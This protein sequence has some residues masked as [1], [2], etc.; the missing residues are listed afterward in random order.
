MWIEN[1][2]DF[3]V[4]LFL[5]RLNLRTAVRKQKHLSVLLNVVQET[6]A[7]QSHWPKT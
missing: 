6:Q 3:N 1:R 7:K 2:L 5:F 4:Y